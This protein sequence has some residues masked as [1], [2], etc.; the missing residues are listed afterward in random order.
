MAHFAELDEN[1]I[2]VRV[3]VVANAEAPDE[4]TGIQ[5]LD[6]I[7]LGKNWKQTSYNTIGGKHLLDGTPFRKNF[8]GIGWV[9]DEGRDAFRPQKPTEGEW[10]ID[11]ATCYWVPIDINS[12]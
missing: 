12:Q 10:E 1:N 2:V 8:A 11:E 5:F 3:I 9:Y 7:G 4:E 6:S